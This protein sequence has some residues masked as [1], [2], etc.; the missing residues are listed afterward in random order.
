[1][2]GYKTYI[3]HVERN[4]TLVNVIVWGH[5]GRK[6]GRK[7]IKDAVWQYPVYSKWLNMAN[8]LACSRA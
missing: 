7:I 4:A 8:T 6:K 2:F 3:M 5:Q 1:M